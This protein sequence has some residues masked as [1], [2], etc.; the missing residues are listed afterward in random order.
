M[1]KCDS[2]KRV[3]CDSGKMV[4]CDSGKRVKHDKRSANSPQKSYLLTFLSFLSRSLTI[5]LR[6]V[7]SSSLVSL[8]NGT[9]HILVCL[10]CMTSEGGLRYGE[11]GFCRQRLSLNTSRLLRGRKGQRE[12][13]RERVGGVKEYSFSE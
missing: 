8:L 4:K 5:S 12:R 10:P 9:A 2:G 13:E 6:A 11:D 7:C 3:K 1:V